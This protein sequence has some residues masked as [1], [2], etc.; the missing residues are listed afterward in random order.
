[1][2]DIPVMPSHRHA[3]SFGVANK[4]MR[5][6]W[7]AAWLIL[8][9][10]TPPPLHAWRCMILRAFGAQIGRDVRV[11][12]DCR[13]WH[14]R[15]LTMADGAVMGRGVRCYNQGHVMIGRDAV[16]SQ[17]VTLCASTHDVNDP[18]FPLLLRPIAIEAHAWIAAEAFIGPGV[19][20]G[21][22]AV[23]GARGVAM[24]DLAHWTVFTGNP[25]QP[26]K[27]RDPS[28]FNG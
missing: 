14:P 22:G 10:P 13:I 7:Q 28:P 17:D 18:L 6:L 25:A 26:L 5:V 11:Y 21:E 24:R 2:N 1:M 4:L 20:V 8:V 19:T 12:G 27:P 15:N 9:R 3:A 16:V 23:L